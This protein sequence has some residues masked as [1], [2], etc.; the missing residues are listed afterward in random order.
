MPFRLASDLA[1]QPE[2]MQ[3]PAITVPPCGVA[4][5]MTLLTLGPKSGK[6][7]TIAGMVADA[8]K[9]GVRCGLLTLDESLSDTLQ[10]LVRFGAALDHVYL[11]DNFEELDLARQTVEAGLEFLG[12]DHLGKLAEQHQNFG[13]GSQG[14]PLLWGRFLSPFTTLA[15][16]HNLAVVALDQARRSDAKYAGSYAK[17]GTVDILCELESKDGGLVGSPRGRV[18][19]PPFRV[20]LDQAGRPV[21][22]EVGQGDSDGAAPH[23]QNVV[24]LRDRLGVLAA[25]QSAEPEGL[26]ATQWERLACEQ[27]GHA[28][29]TFFRIRRSLYT[30]GLVSYTSRLYRVS[31]TGGRYLATQAEPAPDLAW[32]P[33]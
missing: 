2:L 26:K 32:L 14:D 23:C 33:S 29:R 31:P 22:T 28:R 3:P 11:N 8:S 6:S 17:A 12:I 30:D 18:N 4:G 16:E 10:R 15:R 19:L 7:T 25:L 9:L 20:D 5:R 24:S 21:F 13:A 1:A 27:T